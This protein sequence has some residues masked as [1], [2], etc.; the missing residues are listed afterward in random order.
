MWRIDG[1]G[2]PKEV[3]RYAAGEP[4]GVDNDKRYWAAVTFAALATALRR[5]AEPGLLTL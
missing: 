2:Q 4:N 3:Q 1:F 5:S